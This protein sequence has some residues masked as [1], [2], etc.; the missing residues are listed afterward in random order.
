MSEIP[1]TPLPGKIKE[2]F[3]KFQE[4]STPEKVKVNR[5][6]LESLAFKS[7]N[8]QYIIKILRVIGFVDGSNTPTDL[9]RSYK[10]P[11]RGGAV[12]AQGIRTGYKELFDTYPDANRKDREALYA[13]FSSKTGKAKPTVDLMVSTFTNLCQIADFQAEAPTVM[14]K[15]HERIEGKPEVRIRPEKDI[16]SEIHLNIQLHLPPTNDSTVY[17]ALFKSLRKNLLSGEESKNEA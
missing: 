12:L 7:G 14:E 13:F 6:W 5:K 9:W 17:D 16:I 2:Y 10:D 15:P 3:D 11:T 1:Y 8:D 4:V